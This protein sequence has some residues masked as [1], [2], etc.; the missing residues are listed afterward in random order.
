VYGVDGLRYP[1]I[2][3]RLA[4]VVAVLAG[5]S[6]SGRAADPEGTGG[7]DAAPGAADARPGSA[8]AAPGSPDA[9]PGSPDAAEVICPGGFT[10][11]V[12]GSCYRFEGTAQ[13]WQDAETSCE[14]AGAHLAVIDD[15]A[16]QTFIASSSVWIGASEIITP[17][18]FRW[19]TGVSPGF[20]AWASGE[21]GSVGGASCVEA[22]AAPDGW[23]DDNCPEAKPYACEYDGLAADPSQF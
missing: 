9:P 12:P 15:A 21:P 16:E 11:R 10:L 18:T 20:T 14:A 19:V 8:D 2:V 6:F 13:T 17:G 7:L 1:V 5:C 4:F 3:G 23:H 22:R